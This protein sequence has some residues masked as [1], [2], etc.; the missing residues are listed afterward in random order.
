MLK[1]VLVLAV[2][3]LSIAYAQVADSTNVSKLY[4]ATF[5]RAPDSAGLDYWVNSGLSLEEI[6]Q[7]F[8]DQKETQQKY[9]KSQNID[10]FINTV[11]SN[12]LGRTPDSA[13]LKYWADELNSNHISRSSFILAI[14][15]GA[16][17][18]DAMLLNNKTEVA[19]AFAKSGSNDIE[20]AKEILKDVTADISSVTDVL[21]KENLTQYADSDSMVALP[22]KLFVK[23]WKSYLSMGTVTDDAPSQID[24]IANSGIDAIFKYVGNGMGERGDVIEPEFVMKTIVLAREAQKHTGK[25]VMPVMVVYTANA[26][27]GGLGEDDILNYDNL[28][29]HFRSLIRISSTMQLQKDNEHSYPASVILNPDL[30]G[31]WEIS[32]LYGG[33]Y[34][35][36]CGDTDDTSCNNPK[37]ID[38]KKALNEAIDLEKDYKYGFNDGDLKSVY[39]LDSLKSEIAENIS[40]DIFG[41]V[42][43]QNFIIKKFAP[44][45]SFG[46]VFNLWSSG[47]SLWVHDEYPSADEPAQ[48]VVEFINS[49]G[50]YN[51]NYRPDFIVFDKYERDGFSPAGRGY[52]A[53]GSKEWKNYLY[54]V[55][56]ITDTIDTPAMLWQIPGGH[57]PTKNEDVSF[58]YINHSASGGDFFM[59]DKNIGTNIDNIRDDILNIA[60]NP[61]VYNGV[62]NVKELLEQDSDYDWSK[63]QIQ[64]AVNSNVF[65]IL[66]GGGETTG[67]IPIS[68]CMNGGYEWLAQKVAKYENSSTSKSINTRSLELDRSN[69]SDNKT[70]TAGKSVVVG[71]DNRIY[72]CKPFP[73]GQ[74]CKIPAYAPG[75]KSGIWKDAWDVVK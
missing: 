22:D 29:K 17:G 25:N 26:S 28:V 58:D 18:K 41:W 5:N 34:D 64:R 59:G 24:L 36:Y 48:N 30:M 50:L 60:L 63:S 45:V 71:L 51:G 19:L 15:N 69:L 75:G 40:D 39:D 31:S 37:H 1:R 55:K 42:D 61:D 10:E 56:S 74:W 23:G 49:I 52:Y 66:W 13:G 72:K 44:D 38:I 54:Y 70:Y 33:F 2:F 35:V 32:T 9:P 27:G 16:I 6:A 21:Q 7:S 57:M 12:V 46:W 20:K 73:K 8:F 3:I 67:V 11:Y 62:S 4:I 65:A 14:T 47:T 53:F 68:T 43:A